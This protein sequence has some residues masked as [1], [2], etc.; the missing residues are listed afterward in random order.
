MMKMKSK[1]G[2]FLKINPQYHLILEKKMLPDS[3]QIGYYF[4]I[5]Q[6]DL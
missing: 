3:H 6:K 4:S 1:L 2:P 5:L